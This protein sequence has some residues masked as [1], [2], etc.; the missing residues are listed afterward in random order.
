MI[1]QRLSAQLAEEA[2]LG[3]QPLLAERPAQEPQALA[4][5]EQQQVL[6]AQEQLPSAVLA[7]ALAVEVAQ[8]LLQ[9]QQL[10]LPQPQTDPQPESRAR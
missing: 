10:P 3:P 6:A 5:A 1:Q 8:P 4:R 2:Q 7:S 9:Q